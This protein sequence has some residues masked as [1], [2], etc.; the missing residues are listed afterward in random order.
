MRMNGRRK[1]RLLWKCHVK[2]PSLRPLIR[3]EISNHASLN[4]VVHLKIRKSS[5]SRYFFLNQQVKEG[6]RAENAGLKLGDSIVTINEKDT[7]NMT[8]QEA[9]NVLEQAAQQDVKLGVIKWVFFRGIWIKIRM[10]TFTIQ[11]LLLLIWC[12]STLLYKLFIKFD[13]ATC[14]AVLRKRK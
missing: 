5:S 8:L 12:S 9:N 6:S 11:C 7:T 10:S 3:K 4:R 2:N 13:N 1:E 14:S